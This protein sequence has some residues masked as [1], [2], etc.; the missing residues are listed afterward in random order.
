MRWQRLCASCGKS[1]QLAENE[2]QLVAVAEQRQRL[3]ESSGAR[4]Q[5]GDT[6]G[7]C[8]ILRDGRNA[9]QDAEETDAL[10]E[11]TPNVSAFQ[12][13]DKVGQAYRDQK[14]LSI[15][16]FFK[17]EMPVLF[18]YLHRRR[19]FRPTTVRRNTMKIPSRSPT[20]PASMPRHP[21]EREGQP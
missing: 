2:T 20:A 6:L 16:F 10:H 15:F 19:F 17:T 7:I 12:S 13:Q 9:V 8:Y 5:K 1:E 18:P 14:I 21:S 11:A 3:S 4:Q